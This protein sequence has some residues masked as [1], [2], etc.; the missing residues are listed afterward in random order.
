MACTSAQLNRT[1]IILIANASFSA[2]SSDAN[3]MRFELFSAFIHFFGENTSK[4]TEHSGVKN[5]KLNMVAEKRRLLAQH[6]FAFFP[7]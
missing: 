4:M 3:T 2:Q 5:V 6:S 1:A 7:V